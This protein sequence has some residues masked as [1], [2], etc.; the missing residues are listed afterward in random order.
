MSSKESRAY[1]V[2]GPLME[3]QQGSVE[4]VAW[5]WMV[6]RVHGLLTLDNVDWGWVLVQSNMFN[7]GIH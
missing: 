5:P 7:S 6:Q 4:R 3:D 1:H 2:S